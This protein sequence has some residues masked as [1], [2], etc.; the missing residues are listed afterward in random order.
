[1]RLSGRLWPT[2]A[3]PRVHVGFPPYPPW[4]RRLH[5]FH[6]GKTKRVL[7]VSTIR[8]AKAHSSDM[9]FNAR[10]RSTWAGG[11]KARR[12]YGQG[13]LVRSR[14][15]SRSAPLRPLPGWFQVVYA[16]I[17]LKRVHSYRTPRHIR[18]RNGSYKDSHEVSS[19]TGWR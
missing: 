3:S 12:N 14:E 9:S 1:L 5:F 7:T 16:A 11:A 19:L 4:A 15:R 6:T 8:A 17:S 2:L 18:T 13:V 10:D